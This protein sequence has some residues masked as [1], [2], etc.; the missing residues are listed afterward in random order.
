M[1]GVETED[2]D[3]DVDIGKALEETIQSLTICPDDFRVCLFLCVSVT[4]F[5][6]V[7]GMH[8]FI[9]RLTA[10]GEQNNFCLGEGENTCV[11]EEECTEEVD[12]DI[13]GNDEDVEEEETVFGKVGERICALLSYIEEGESI[14]NATFSIEVEDSNGWHLQLQTYFCSICK[15]GSWKTE[16]GDEQQLQSFDKKDGTFFIL[17]IGV[18]ILEED[19]HTGEEEADTEEGK[20]GETV[21]EEG[22]TL[23][24]K[25]DIAG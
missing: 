25:F 14:C 19:E 24:Y 21:G 12:L 17:E 5:V 22:G 18:A 1:D 10:E 4:I 6:F 13:D 15:E 23:L 9:C 11:G 3:I 20:T 16:N 2:D 8:D 7:R